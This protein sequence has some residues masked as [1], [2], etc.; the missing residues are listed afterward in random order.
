MKDRITILFFLICLNTLLTAQI[1]YKVERMPFNTSNSEMGP[2]IYKNGLI[3]SSNRKNDVV[4][5]VTDQSGSFLYNLY[6]AEKK[7][8]NKWSKPGLFS[9]N[10]IQ[11]YNEGSVSVTADGKTVFFT[12]TTN[13]SKSIGDKLTGDTLT[14]GI[15]IGT[16]GNDDWTSIVEF[17]YNNKGYDVGY[18][19]ISEDGNKLYFSSRNPDGHGGYDIYC[20]EKSGNTWQTPVNLGNEINSAENEVFPYIFHDDRL[21]FASRGHGGHGG[22][23]LFY[24]DLIDGKWARPVNLPE[25]FNSTFDDFA[26]VSNTLMDTGYFVSNRK[27]NDDIFRFESTLPVF[28][29]C[30]PQVN[31]EFCYH[32]EEAKTINLDSTTLKYEWDLGDS[33]KIQQVI[34]DHCYK[35]PGYYMI[36]LNFIDTLTGTITKNAASYDLLIERIEQ[37]FITSVDTGYVDQEIDIDAVNSNIKKFTIQNY[38]WDFGD[39]DLETGSKLLHKY[40]K[41]GEYI[42]RLGVTGNESDN[43]QKACVTKKIVILRKKE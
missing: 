43:S 21:Y 32:F 35:E 13:A 30:N 41:Q 3:F 12:A 4:I 19:C 8:E 36:Q 10:L 22:L 16:K 15:F 23:D 39:G 24:S 9:K 33:T 42:I 14:N 25:P 17:P 26:F 2:V 1:Y 5:V 28:V 27:G 38:Y 29:N 6:F 34:A 31:E 7:S 20:S 40:V 37:P 18:P 11:K